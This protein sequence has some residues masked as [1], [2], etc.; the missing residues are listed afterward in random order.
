[1]VKFTYEDLKRKPEGTAGLRVLFGTG[2]VADIIAY[3][4]F[5]FLIFTFYSAVMRVNINAI[6]VVYIIWTLWNSLNDVIFGTISDRS[7]FKKFLGGGR[8]GP[9]M[10]MMILP[11]ALIMVLLFL[12]P[13][14]DVGENPG[15]TG[16]L[17]FKIGNIPFTVQSIYMLIIM[18]FF[19]TIYTIY[20]INHTSLYPEMFLTHKAREKAGAMRRVMMVF[21]LLVAFAVPTFIVDVYIPGDPESPSLATSLLQYRIAGIIFC[22]LIFIFG[23]V[24][25]VWGIR[26]PPYE[27]MQKKNNLSWK[28]SFRHTIKNK[29]FIIFIFASSMNWFVFGLVPMIFPAYGQIVIGEPDAFRVTIILLVLFIA[30]IPGVYFWSWLD[31]KIGSKEAFLVCMIAWGLCFIPLFFITDYYGVMAVM[32]VMGLIFGGPPYFIDRN[33]SNIA[34]EDELRTGQRRE[35]SF[36]GVHAFI[37]RLATILNIISINIV[38]TFNGWGDLVEAAQGASSFG[39]QMLMSAFPLGAMVIG[40]LFL[41]FYRIGKKKADNIQLKMKELHSLEE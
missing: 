19:D 32:V 5:T 23:L 20:S 15:E 38:F 40:I 13:I 1:M 34:D 16:L 6:T 14:T 12:S 9:Y 33:I 39:I 2:E 41:S 7:R 24:H 18:V 31:K 29:N 27:E 11:L 3:Q 22:V 4:G 10:K 17:L 26:E 37:I 28:E 21:G 25:V 8:R 30:S 36:Y 35:A